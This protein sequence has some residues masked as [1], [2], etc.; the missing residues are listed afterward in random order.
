MNLFTGGLYRSCG[1]ETVFGFK[2]RQKPESFIH[3]R[4]TIGRSA[5]GTTTFRETPMVDRRKSGGAEE[6]NE[7]GTL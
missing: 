4:Y 2:S 5:E 1:L 6:G 3:L 7:T